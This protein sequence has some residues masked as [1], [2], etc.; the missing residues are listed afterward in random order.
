MNL[1]INAHIQ[2]VVYGSRYVA[3]EHEADRSVYALDAAA[4]LGIAMDFWDIAGLA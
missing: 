3:P 2:R 1:I 4:E